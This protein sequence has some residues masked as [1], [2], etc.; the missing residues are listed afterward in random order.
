MTSYLFFSLSRTER[1]WNNSLIT[2]RV[3]FEVFDCFIPLFYIA[4]YQLN[5]VALRRELV[6][7]FWGKYNPSFA[8]HVY[9]QRKRLVHIPLLL[10][11]EFTVTQP[12]C[13]QQFLKKRHFLTVDKRPTMHLG[14]LNLRF[15][16]QRSCNV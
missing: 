8:Q 10:K 13:G 15:T 6:G 3:L 12:L 16:I 9:F 14:A 7:L 2:K 1:E 11:R 5:V 4:F